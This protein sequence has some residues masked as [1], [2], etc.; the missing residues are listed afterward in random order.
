MIKEL[1][2]RKKEMINF[3]SMG[4]TIPEISI[5]M[6]KEFPRTTYAGVALTL[7]R[8]GIK[9]NPSKM[10]RRSTLNENYFEKINTH[11]T[12]YFFGLICADGCVSSDIKRVRIG[13]KEED[14]YLIDELKKELNFSGK[15]LRYKPSLGGFQRSIQLYSQKM[16]D[17]LKFHGCVDR[18]SLTLEFPNIE[19][20]FLGS[21][22]RGYFDGDGWVSKQENNRLAF[23][24]I[25]SVPFIEKT[26]NILKEYF[27]IESYIYYR[28]EYC[29]LHI[30]KQVEIVKIRDIMYEFDSVSL[31]RKKSNFYY[32][33]SY[34]KRSSKNRQKRKIK[35]NL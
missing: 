23:G 14:S 27:N 19:K 1:S 5:C 21:F 29:L 18:K 9:A 35:V 2:Y 6:Q 16:V 28:K 7:S 13:L 30:N 34:E 20:Q 25:G 26:K 24:I 31:N 33:L 17:D 15:I 32:D 22:F 11:R 4:L 10:P 12:A 3:H 8:Q